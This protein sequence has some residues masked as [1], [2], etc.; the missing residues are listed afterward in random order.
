MT[1]QE[2]IEVR[3]P[4]HGEFFRIHPDPEYREEVVLT[5]DEQGELYLIAANMVPEI[6]RVAPDRIERC[7]LFTAVNKDGKTF[8]WPVSLPVPD[9]HPAYH[10]MEDWICLHGVQ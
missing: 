9:D 10:A 2:H 1:E 7:M 4:R 6:E 3:A 5:R 8:M